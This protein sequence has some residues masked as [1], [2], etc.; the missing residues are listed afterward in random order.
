MATKE[1]GGFINSKPRR[2]TGLA[3]RWDS[4]RLPIVMSAEMTVSMP[5]QVSKL[6]LRAHNPF[7]GLSEVILCPSSAT[8]GVVIG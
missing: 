8:L 6:R 3:K 1:G 7:G 4:N 2:E 5:C